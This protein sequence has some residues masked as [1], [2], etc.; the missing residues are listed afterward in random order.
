MKSNLRVT[1]PDVIV[2]GAGIAGLTAA[3]F[4]A[5]AGLRVVVLER[6]TIAGGC[7]SFY[8]RGGYRCEVGATLVGGFGA[9]GVHRRI[10]GRLG[11]GPEAVSVEPSMIV[12]LPGLEVSRFG[13][14]RWRVERRR[15]FGPGAEPFWAH[16]ERLADLAWDLSGRFPAIPSDAAGLMGLARAL[17]PAHV[18]LAGALGRTVGSLLPDDASL[19][20]RA[21]VD[22]QLLITAQSD[23]ASTD[24]AYGAT[25]L[26]LARE[27]TFHLAGGI[28]EIA[29][30]LGRAVRVRGSS[31]AYATPVAAIEIRGGRARGVVLEDGARL[32]APVVVAALP[33]WTLARLVAAGG[34][35]LPGMARIEALPQRWGAFT[36]YVGLPPGSVPPRSALHHQII[37]DPAGPPGEGNTAFLSFSSPDEKGRARNG[38]TA[39][40]LSTHTDVARWERAGD[41][42]TEP[43]LRERY[44]AML[45][46][47]LEQVVPGAVA[48]AD[49]VEF[50]TPWTFERYTGRERGLVGGIPQTPAHA[51]LRA[52]SHRSGIARLRLCGDTIFPG[53]STVGASLSGIAAA[54]AALADLGHHRFTG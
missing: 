21:F 11:G 27:G 41:D 2:V 17:R 39:V 26:D 14:E 43:A 53:Q 54:R 1:E 13:D 42:G 30:A 23:A 33:V 4:L 10:F 32:R 44:G 50:G 49:V 12:H 19:A 15:A 51:V 52:F 16:L 38:G 34:A 28:G 7:A 3:A 45:L 22:A 25:A 5:D 46:A 36:A 31:I 9:R 6:H 40:T 18:R 8:Q 20:L 29:T 47:A 37:A 35:R 48:R 24:L